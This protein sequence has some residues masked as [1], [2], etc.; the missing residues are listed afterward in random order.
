MSALNLAE[1]GGRVVSLHVYSRPIERCLVYSPLQN[2]C[3]E[4]V[5]RYTSEYGKLC[6]GVSL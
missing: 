3:G 5:L 6:A 4:V 1:F 2:R